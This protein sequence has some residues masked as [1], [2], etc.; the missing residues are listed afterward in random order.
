MRRQQRLTL[1]GT[2]LR[3]D[4][5]LIINTLP[6]TQ[7]SWHAQHSSRCAERQTQQ[8]T[9]PRIDAVC[10]VLCQGLHHTLSVPPAFVGL[11]LMRGRMSLK[12]SHWASSIKLP[13]WSN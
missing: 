6:N 4:P 1:S 8:P 11:P 12:L 10:C 3:V 2:P 5:I 13:H 7:V 9:S